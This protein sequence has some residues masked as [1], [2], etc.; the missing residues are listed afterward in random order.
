MSVKRRINYELSEII[1]SPIDNCSAGLISEHDIYKWQ[2]TIIGPQG[3]PYEGGLFNLRVNFPLDYPFKPPIV[4]FTTKIYHCN[5]SSAGNICL[6]ILQNEWSPALTITQ[7]LLSICSLMDDPNPED[8]L[9]PTIA[10]QLKTDKT[11]HDK[12]ARDWTLQYA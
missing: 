8:P 4:T 9:E 7:V 11:A 1:S 2:A 6:D 10:E 3:S 5:I 12:I